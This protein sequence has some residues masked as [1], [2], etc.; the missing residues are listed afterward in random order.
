MA[1]T[2]PASAY[3]GWKR[4]FLIICLGQAF[5]VMGSAAVQFA[6]IWWLTVKTQSAVTLTAA[7][8]AGFVPFMILGPLA[9]VLADRHNRKTVMMLADGLI[10]ASSAVLWAAFVIRPDLPVPF[11]YLAIFIR[12]IGSTFHNP[13]MQ[14][15]VPMLV[16]PE[17][18]TKAG[19]WGQL[20]QSL[21]SMLGPVLG[22][23]L[24]EIIPIGPLMLV[25]ITGAAFAIISLIFVRIPDIP[26]AKEPP[27]V[28]SDMKRGFIAMRANKP[29][30]AIFPS[31]MLVNILFSPLGSL[32]PLL[33][34]VYFKGGALH[35][36]ICQ[37]LFAGGM[38]ISSAVMGV[39]GGMR[40]RF[41]MVASFT[42]VLGLSCALSVA[43]GEGGFW[44]FAACSVILGGCGTF[45]NVP[46]MAY[47]QETTAPDVMGKVLSL[48]M[49]S[50]TLAMPVGLL[51]AGPVSELIGVD[52]WFLWSGAAIAATGV[53]CRLMTRKYDSETMRPQ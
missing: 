34:R 19:G 42:V 49:M 27:R 25:D 10:A 1:N 31:I 9:G 18:L 53:L 5:S 33:V 30:M 21:A 16:P 29:L 32:F 48:I 38:L 28:F 3:N 50:M 15:A 52:R 6:I 39:W 14:A 2:E 23:V 22:A 36:S 12:G 43:F 45:L 4:T 41:L 20:I 44:L 26:R 35:N 51:A 17:M 13:A 8:I 47:L 7:T 46:A 11:I 40:R 37:F 24:I